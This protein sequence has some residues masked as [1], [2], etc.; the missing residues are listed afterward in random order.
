MNIVLADDFS[1]AAEIAG[2]A[3]ALGLSA[4]VQKDF[5]PRDVDLIVIDTN[6]R[7]QSVQRAQEIHRCLG[8]TLRRHEPA[9]I[10]K[11]IDSV[12]R[13]HV[14]SEINQLMTDFRFERTLLVSANPQRGRTIRGGQLFIDGIPLHETEFRHDPEY[15]VRDPSVLTALRR[16]GSSPFNTRDV[17]VVDEQ[18]FDPTRQQVIFVGNAS[19]TFDLSCWAAHQNRQTL[20][21]GGA[22]FFTACMKQSLGQGAVQPQMRLIGS[23]GGP[24]LSESMRRAGRRMLMVSGS[25]FDIEH[26]VAMCQTLG[27][28]IVF[29][30]D[31]WSSQSDVSDQQ[32]VAAT[33]ISRL[34]LDGRLALHFAPRLVREVAPEVAVQAMV[35]V[36]RQILSQTRVD[37]L[38]LEGGT[39]A[40]AVISALG[41][42]HFEVRGMLDRGTVALSPLPAGSPLCIVKPGSYPW[43]QDIWEGFGRQAGVELNG[44]QKCMQNKESALT[45]ASSPLG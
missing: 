34:E 25:A 23:Q 12:L 10:Y 11:K 18:D 44:I 13:G 42:E 4:D 39:T 20:C 5:Q 14:L 27:I 8:E 17:L 40:S 15:P 33:A 3:T 9:L 31:D 35:E 38:L 26:R 22:E 45:L 1:G 19:S 2:L 32:Q 7:S 37:V 36:L 30:R 24:E 21:A 43:P 6:S 41:W 16:D 29:L 28:P